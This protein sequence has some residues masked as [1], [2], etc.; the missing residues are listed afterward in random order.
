M[1]EGCVTG[2]LYVLGQFPGALLDRTSSHEVHGTVFLLPEDAE[3]LRRFDSYEEYEP[4]S[5]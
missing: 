4:N 2:L 5:P 3:I 1:D